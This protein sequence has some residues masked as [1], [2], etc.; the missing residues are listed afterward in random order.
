MIPSEIKW[1]KEWFQSLKYVPR[2]FWRSMENRRRF[3]DEIKIKLQIFKPSDWGNIPSKRLHDLGAYTLLCKY[4]N[5]S[6]FNCLSS[7]Y[8]GI[9]IFFLSDSVRYQMGQKMVQIHPQI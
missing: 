3:L 4:Y 8:K 9:E 2:S 6:L 5:N 7:V 1:K